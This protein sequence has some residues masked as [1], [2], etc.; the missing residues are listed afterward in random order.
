MVAEGLLLWVTVSNRLGVELTPS[1]LS[2]AID[3]FKE[4]DIMSK[5]KERIEYLAPILTEAR[6][7]D[8]LKVRSNDAIFDF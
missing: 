6:V 1:G 7:S 4:K 5:E 3:I 2:L 8:F